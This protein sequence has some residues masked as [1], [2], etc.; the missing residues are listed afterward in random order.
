MTQEVITVQVRTI[1]ADEGKVLTNGKSYSDPGGKV[2]LASNDSAD[3]WDEITE[4]EYQNI[5][6]AELEAQS[7]NL[8]EKV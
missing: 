3:N 4:E 8:N 1:K 2:Y 6:Q 7:L 5:L